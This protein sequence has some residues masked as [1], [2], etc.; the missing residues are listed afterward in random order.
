MDSVKIYRLFQDLPLPN[1]SES[2]SVGY[3]IVSAEDYILHPFERHPFT[4]GIYISFEG[5]CYA[6]V[7]PRSGLALN[8]GIDVLAGV[9]DSSY[10]GEI[11]VILINLSQAPFTIKRGDRIAQLIFERAY[12]PSFDELEN[13]NELPNSI[14]G[15]KGFGSSGK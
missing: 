7:A 3:D 13:L 11:K 8:G 1:R 14:R 4:T 12:T 9:I 5:D 2:G 15:D 6:R 10:R